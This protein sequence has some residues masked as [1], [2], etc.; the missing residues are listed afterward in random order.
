MSTGPAA[1]RIFGILM[2]RNDADILRANI[3]L[4][5]SLGC[6]RVLVVENGSSDE[7]PQILRQLA[8]RHPVE[9]STDTGELRQPEIVTDLAHRARE[10]GADWVIPLDTDEFW[11]PTRPLAELCAESDGLGA[12]EVPRIEFVTARDQIHSTRKGPLRATM[13]VEPVLLGDQAVA[14]FADKR[15]SMFEIAPPSKLLMR[16]TPDLTI[17]RGAHGAT[18]LAGPL[19]VNPDLAIFHLAMRSR[20]EAFS[21][22]EHG[23]RIN[24]VD[25]RPNVSVQN[26]YWLEMAAE[27]RLDEAWRAHSYEDGAL[28]VAGRRVELVEDDRLARMLEPWL[29]TRPELIGRKVARRLRSHAGGTQAVR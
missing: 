11:R 5:L 17:A 7:T 1:P 28:E 15:R 13:R 21:R 23:E 20:D 10:Q 26:R 16:T 12:L 27:D 2:T 24:R 9:W 6:E 18:G 4:H 3:L 14:E 8:R 29:L 19:E 22:V 25:A